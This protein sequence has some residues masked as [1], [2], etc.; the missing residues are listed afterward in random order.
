MDG[1]EREDVVEY[2]KKFLRRVVSIGFLNQDNAPNDD[3]KAALSNDLECPSQE[4]IDKTLIFF[5]DETTFQINDDQGTFWGTKGTIIMKPKG[6]GSGIIVSDFIDE[7]SGYL[8]LTQEEYDRAK[9]ID[10]NIWIQ[11]RC[12]LEYGESREG[13][14][15]CDR[16]M[17]Q[18]KMAVKIAEIKYPKS[19]NRNHVWVFD[20]S[21]CHAAMPDDA[22]DV[23]KQNERKAWWKTMNNKR[24]IMEWKSTK[25]EFCHRGLRIVLEKR[26]VNTCGMNADQ[27]HKVLSSHSDFQNEKSLIERFLVEEKRHIAYFL[28]KFHPELN[29]M[30]RVWAESKKYTRAHCNYSLPSIRKNICPALDSVPLE[31]VQ[32][33]FSKVRHYM[34][35]YLEGL[36]G[37]LELE[38][39][40][41]TYKKEVKSHRRISDIQ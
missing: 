32:K 25:Y 23:R 41:K 5:L 38:Q 40:V 3:A 20:H 21:S 24:W 30:E 28:P 39:L 1:H 27:M 37:G 6:K 36:P 12:Y 13:Y 11:V 8:S 2:R 7:K 35:A 17:E 9:Q 26:G 33:H 4:V 16:F 10:P 34:F 31:S 14:W 29:P 22:L 18:I 19:E 15:N